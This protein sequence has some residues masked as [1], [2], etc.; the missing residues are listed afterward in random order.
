MAFTKPLLA[1]TTLVITVAAGIYIKSRNHQNTHTN[2]LPPVN[3]SGANKL[4]HIVFL[5]KEN[6][7]FDTYF[8]TFPGADGATS[9]K[10]SDGK[11]V[12]LSRTPDN[13]PYDIGHSWNDAIKAM[14]D[15]K[16]DRFDQVAHGTLGGLLLPYTQLTKA[17]IPNYFAYAHNFVLADR[18]FSSLK[19]PSF[20]NHLYT[21]AAQ[22]GGAVN[23]PV[24]RRN[25]T[26]SFSS[27]VGSSPDY[28]WGCDADDATVDVIDEKGNRKERPCFDFQT[29][30][31]SLENAH[32]TWKY[33]A[34]GFGQFGYQWSALDAVKHIR[35]GPLWQT[36]VVP[37][38]QFVQ[39]ALNGKLPAVS[40]LVT[41]RASEHPPF[42]TCVGENWTVQQLN[43]VMQGPDWN[44]TVVF[45]TWD[46]FGGFYDHVAPPKIDFYGLGPRVPLLIISPFARKGFVSHS[47]YE[48]SSFL[49][50]LEK[51]FNLPPLSERDQHANDMF[52]SFDFSQQPLSPL[53]LETHT[54][55]WFN[56]LW[57]GL[58]RRLISRDVANSGELD[59]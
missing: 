43:A 59:R 4:R 5:I 38:T 10:T 57:W 47:T 31:D 24:R 16:M 12:Q 3:A 9:G 50:F 22:A 25:T 8:G 44:S 35:Q 11:T 29:V 13:M 27:S 58:R 42:S 15:G 40:W 14:D 6:R 54:C 21:V 1:A 20:P 56:R 36:N 41:G 55:P 49:T 30:V 17:E 46:D 23:N 34:P 28:I 26:A 51:R 52:D 7:S 18:M 32:V 2:A 33:Y 19:G 45:L 53:I 39:D 37:D 48:F